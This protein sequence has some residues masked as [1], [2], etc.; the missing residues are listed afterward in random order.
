MCNPNEAEPLLPD[1][2]AQAH[3]EGSH[4]EESVRSGSGKSLSSC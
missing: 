3:R 2:W 4:I 1:R